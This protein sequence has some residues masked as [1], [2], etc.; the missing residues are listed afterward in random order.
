MATNNDKYYS[1]VTSTVVQK[2][3]Y[4]TKKNIAVRRPLTKIFISNLPIILV[5]ATDLINMSKGQ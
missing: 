5:I 1:K 3:I 2:F 4:F